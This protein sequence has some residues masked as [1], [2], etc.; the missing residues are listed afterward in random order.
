MRIIVSTL[1]IT[2]INYEAMQKYS[3]IITTYGYNLKQW[4]NQ[5]ILGIRI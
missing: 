3:L 1:N 2:S 4:I 5:S